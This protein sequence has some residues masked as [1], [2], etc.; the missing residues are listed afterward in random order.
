MSTTRRNRG[1]SSTAQDA[2][3]V[4]ELGAA[5]GESLSSLRRLVESLCSLEGL[6]DATTPDQPDE[7]LLDGDP[8]GYADELL[9]TISSTLGDVRR[10]TEALGKLPL[11]MVRQPA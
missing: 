6:A 1:N 7:R 9:D 2:P 10:L 3:A 4:E 11:G 8:T 5:A